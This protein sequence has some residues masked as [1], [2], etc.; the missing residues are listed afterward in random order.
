MTSLAQQLFNRSNTTC[1]LCTANDNLAVYEVPPTSNANTENSIL[2]CKTCL[3]QLEKNE[4]FHNNDS[5]VKNIK[6]RLVE[7]L[8]K[9]IKTD[10]LKLSD[11]NKIWTKFCFLDET[12]TLSNKE[13][14]Y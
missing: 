7:K 13:E 9:E 4:Q 2:V 1:E 10:N 6:E 11:F 12:G 14:Q 8:L 5:E 3:D